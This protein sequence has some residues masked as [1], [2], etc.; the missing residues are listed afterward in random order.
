MMSPGRAGLTAPGSAPAVAA[1]V[2]ALGIVGV[3]LADPFRHTV[4]P[5]CPFHALT[6]LWCPFCGGTRAL[7][8][9]MHGHTALML[10]CNALFP[11][12]AA[13]A[14]WGWLGWLGRSLGWWDLPMPRGR[15]LAVVAAVV[16]LAFTL[17]R[18]LPGFADLAPPATT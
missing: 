13:L 14:L 4:T 3:G 7:W 12:V 9:A 17:L 11:L 2:A 18:N 16:L 8:A 10:H 6:G 1:G 5:P 15:P